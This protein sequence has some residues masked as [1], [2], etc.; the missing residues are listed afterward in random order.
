MKFAAAQ[1]SFLLLIVFLVTGHSAVALTE[2][3]RLTS[4]AKI[5]GFLKYYHPEV[6]KG[7]RDWDQQMITLLPEVRMAATAEELSTIYAKL[8]EQLGPVTNCKKCGSEEKVSV[9]LRRNLD[10]S[11]LADSRMLT[12]AL[13]QKLLHLKNN[14]NQQPNFYAKTRLPGVAN[15]SNEK[16]YEEMLFPSEEY[17][18]LALFRYWNAIHYFFPYKYA[19]DKDW[20][21][22]LET[23][24]P[25][26]KDAKDLRAYNSALWQM[27]SSVQ[28]SHSLFVAKSPETLKAHRNVN[29]TGYISPYAISFVGRKP[30]VTGFRNDS[31]AALGPLQL[32]DVITHLN[33]LPVDS[34]IERSKIS[35]PASNQATLLRSLKNTLLTG[36]TPE[37]DITFERNGRS[38]TQKLRLYRY[39][40]L[41]PKRNQPAPAVSWVEDGIAYVHMGNLKETQVDSTMQ[42]LMTSKAIIFDLRYYPQ[43]T[44]FKIAPYLTSKKVVKTLAT[45]PD[46]TFPGIFQSLKPAVIQPVKGVCYKGKVIMIMNE[47]TQSQGEY[48]VMLFKASPRSMTVGSHTAGADGNVAYLPLPGGVEAVFT[49]LGVYYPNR[50]ET[51]RVGLLPDIEVKPTIKGIKDQRDE[52]LEKALQ[53]ARTEM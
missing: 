37:M 52:L 7:E 17:R 21:Q 34:I 53:V 44:G 51:Q 39:N 41:R 12:P 8:L 46:F 50:Q 16:Y 20:N 5:W 36:N 49:G 24:I 28:D 27:V 35:I 38:V 1:V 42:S 22:V 14:R 11:F 18:L 6:A 29:G 9:W 3:E 23:L 2:T 32:G 10:L 25:L 15:F 19:I 43:L 33:H 4:W 48:T 47:D 30:V 13:Q 26:F 31:V 40:E 45:G